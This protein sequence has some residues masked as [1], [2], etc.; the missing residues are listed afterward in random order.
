MKDVR[1]DGQAPAALE[2]GAGEQQ[3]TPVLVGIEGVKCRAVEHLRAV[4]EVHGNFRAG[5]PARPQREVQ[6]Q[7]ADGDAQ[8]REAR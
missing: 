2:G 3:E 5:K 7:I 1:H 4:H 6:A 8:P